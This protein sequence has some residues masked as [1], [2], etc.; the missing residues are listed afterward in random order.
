[1]A[2]TPLQPGAAPA[3]TSRCDSPDAINKL[4]LEIKDHG[5]RLQAV[6]WA[7]D[8]CVDINAD[9]SRVIDR[10]S[11]CLSLAKVAESISLATNDLA[12]KIEMI[13]REL[14]K[15]GGA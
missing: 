9:D 4:A 2:T 6:L 1:M 10:L 12:E 8:Q 14:S 15:A 5:W 13:S 3:N 7:I 11:H